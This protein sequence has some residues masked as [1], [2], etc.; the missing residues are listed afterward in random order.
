MGMAYA[1]QAR[2]EHHA[3]VA[4]HA[5]G[6]GSVK[7]V[8]AG[9]H[10]DGTQPAVRIARQPAH[11]SRVLQ[12]RQLHPAALGAAR[13]SRW[14]RWGGGGRRREA[15]GRSRHGRARGRG[16]GGRRRG[17]SEQSAETVAKRGIAQERLDQIGQV[18]LGRI[19]RRAASAR[20]VAHHD[21]GRSAR[22]GFAVESRRAGR[23]RRSRRTGGSGGTRRRARVAAAAL[24]TA[25][26]RFGRRARRRC[27][28]VGRRGRGRFR[29]R[30]RRGSGGG[31]A[32]AWK[33]R[34]RRK[35]KPRRRRGR[36][37]R[38]HGQARQRVSA[39]HGSPRPRWYMG[40]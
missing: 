16:A 11:Q 3:I 22:S 40:R 6:G 19:L 32:R 1:L 31:W 2:L 35:T 27:G 30:G 20:A 12:G 9:R 33:R 36:G 13:R 8:A 29:R 7:T 37:R 38:N 26:R 23:T 4:Q 17:R 14:R 18:N 39:I 24:G 21:A 28:C 5:H 10:G 34:R 15:S 25:T